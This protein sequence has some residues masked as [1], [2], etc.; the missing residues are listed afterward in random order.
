[1]AACSSV[2]WT[3]RFQT[4]AHIVACVVLTVMTMVSRVYLGVHW[5]SDVITGGALGTVV[6]L[7]FASD[8]ACDWITEVFFE[9][10]SDPLW[11]ALV[12]AAIINLVGVA[13]YVLY[14][15][16]GEIDKDLL[17]FIQGSHKNLP[18]NPGNI[19]KAWWSATTATGQ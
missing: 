11:P 10:S 1:M 13:Q 5:A 4:P 2:F 17:T 19:R 18:M 3:V 6:G 8:F 14:F 15:P 12:M 7:I 16:Y 9:S